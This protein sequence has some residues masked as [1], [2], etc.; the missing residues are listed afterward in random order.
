MPSNHWH[1]VGRSPVD[2]GPDTLRAFFDRAGVTH[3]VITGPPL[4]A[5][6]V[7]GGR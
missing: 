5:F 4:T 6:H 2:Y 1:L 7:E 3:A